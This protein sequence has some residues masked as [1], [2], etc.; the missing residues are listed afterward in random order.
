VCVLEVHIVGG[1][2]CS[3][4]VSLL[5]GGVSPRSR[6]VAAFPHACTILLTV[7]L[8]SPK[9]LLLLPRLGGQEAWAHM[10]PA[11][12]EG[13]VQSLPLRGES[14]TARSVDQGGGQS[15]TREHAALK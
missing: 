11:Y 15:S 9:T 3:H 14:T 10:R 7:R 4:Q 2:E 12:P 1:S 6:S 8:F 13:L 5:L